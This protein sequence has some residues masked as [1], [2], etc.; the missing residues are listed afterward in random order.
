MCG[1]SFIA[2]SLVKVPFTM[3]EPC[4]PINSTNLEL[5]TVVSKNPAKESAV[6]NF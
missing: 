2:I 4:F 6:E 1:Q 3:E 5:S